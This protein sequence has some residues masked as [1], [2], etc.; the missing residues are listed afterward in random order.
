MLGL[1]NVFEDYITSF[2]RAVR[3][4]RD[5]IILMSY[6]RFILFLQLKQRFMSMMVWDK[7]HIGTFFACY[8]ASV[9]REI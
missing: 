7:S 2:M 8:I 9:T 3:L 1:Y 6:G 4:F 5:G